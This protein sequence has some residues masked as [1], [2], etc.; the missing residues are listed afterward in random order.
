VEFE[1]KN[2]FKT[3]YKT[4]DGKRIEG[5]RVLVDCE[6]G[7]TVDGWCV[8]QRCPEGVCVPAGCADWLLLVCR[9]PRRLGGGLGGETRLPKEPKKPGTAAIAPLIAAAAEP[10]R[11]AYPDR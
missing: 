2:D 7:R 5:R 6:R 9:R 8:W 10:P 1:H 3:A 4:A 11:S